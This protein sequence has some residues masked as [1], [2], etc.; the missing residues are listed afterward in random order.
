MKRLIELF[1]LFLA[2]RVLIRKIRK[3]ERLHKN[4]KNCRQKRRRMDR[5]L[6]LA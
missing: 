1:R 6:G 3:W 2:H 5:E 4:E